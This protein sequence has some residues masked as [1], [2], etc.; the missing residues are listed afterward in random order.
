MAAIDPSTIIKELKSGVYRPVYFLQGDEPF[1]IDY[2]TDYIEDK[3]L[4][5]SQKGFNQVIMYGKDS[6]ANTIALNAKRFPMMSERQVVIVKEAQE[7][8]D[9]NREQGIK[10][11]SD[12][13]SNPLP[14]TVLVLAYKNKTLDGRKGL[15]KALD[16]AGALINS[17][18]LYDN[19]VPEWTENYVKEQGYKINKRALLMLVESVGA[20]LSKLSNEIDKVI[21]NFEKGTEI[22]EDHIQKYVGISKDYNVFELQNALGRKDV[23]KTY[24]IVNYFTK[25]PKA[26]PLIPIISILYSY[27]TKIIL[28]HTYAGTDDRGLANTLGVNPYFVKDYKVA[29]ANYT[30]SKLYQAISAIKQ[31]DLQSKGITGGTMTEGDI[32]KELIF[33]LLH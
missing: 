6:D 15:A 3:C 28:S 30:L 11:L 31:A 8:S 20:N 10:I 19:Q 5:E 24:K 7:V 22:E 1:Y 16:K 14:S 32:L 4:E 18:K 13:V 29:K 12:Y 26:N 9:I 21:I 2:I 33:K 17:K 23:I 25:N 27:Y